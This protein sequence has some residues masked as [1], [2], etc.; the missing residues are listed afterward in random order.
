MEQE[1]TEEWFAKT[2]KRAISN[3][4]LGYENSLAFAYGM[5][6]GWLKIKAINRRFA[7]ELIDNFASVE[8]QGLDYEDG[9]YEA[10]EK[11]YG[12]CWM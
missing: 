9:G 8:F 2:L 6:K 7:K 4:A 3:E 11:R 1:H 12:R 5:I 10:L